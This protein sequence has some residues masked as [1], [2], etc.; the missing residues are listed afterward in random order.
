MVLALFL[1]RTSVGQ[2]QPDVL[3]KAQIPTVIWAEALFDYK[4][5]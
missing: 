2:V 5:A 1:P 3:P 4:S